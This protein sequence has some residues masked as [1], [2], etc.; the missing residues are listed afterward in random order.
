MDVISI[1]FVFLTSFGERLILKITVLNITIG[2]YG[3]AVCCSMK[4]E[5][6]EYHIF[7]SNGI[8]LPPLH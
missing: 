7:G 8:Q 6:Y 4:L 1:K 5:F 2:C 3:I